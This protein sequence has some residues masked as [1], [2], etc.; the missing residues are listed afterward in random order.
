MKIELSIDISDQDISDICVTAFEGGINSWCGRVKILIDTVPNL[1]E[2]EGIIAS[3]VIAKG[4][5][6]KL[7]DAEDDEETWILS[8]EN[9][10]T[11]L[12][13]YFNECYSNNNEISFDVGNIDAGD[14]DSI[15]QYAL[16]NELVYS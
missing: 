9:F 1:A 10:K 7:Y 12:E 11:G 3:D 14:A 15:I 5:S 8:P 13:K 4:G 2:D 6:L 16:F